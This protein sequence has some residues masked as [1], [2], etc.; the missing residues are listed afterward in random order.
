MFRPQMSRSPMAVL[1]CPVPKSPVLKWPSSKV[2]S[3]TTHPQMSHPQVLV[4]KCRH[5]VVFR[6]IQ[7][8]LKTKEAKVLLDK[9]YFPNGVQL[10][11]DKQS[12]LVAETERDRLIR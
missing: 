4:L 10:F 7:L 12:V 3:S 2:L 9:I 11:P 1:K 6:I 8:N 5:A